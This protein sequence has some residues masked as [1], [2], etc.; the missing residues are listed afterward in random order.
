MVASIFPRC[1]NVLVFL[2][3]ILQYLCFFSSYY[4]SWK[5]STR[6]TL[7]NRNETRTVDI[8]WVIFEKLIW[9]TVPRCAVVNFAVDRSTALLNASDSSFCFCFYSNPLESPCQPFATKIG[10]PVIKKSKFYL[11]S[12]LV[13]LFLMRMNSPFPFLQFSLV[14]PSILF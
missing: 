7:R 4:I 2:H 8:R 10:V 3:P 1:S 12:C 6:R 13:W 11:I 14:V 5:C 9:T